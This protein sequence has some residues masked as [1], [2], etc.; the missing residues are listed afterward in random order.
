MTVRVALLSSGLL[1]SSSAGLESASSRLQLGQS[2]RSYPALGD[3]RLR[4]LDLSTIPVTESSEPIALKDVAIGHSGSVGSI[5]FVV[6][7]PGCSLCREHGLQLSELATRH[8]DDKFGLWGIVKETN[9]DDQGLLDFYQQYFTFDIY[10]D[11]LLATYEAMGNRMIRLTTWN[12]I[13][14]YRGFWDLT[15]RLQQKNI[16]GNL[17]G[18]G[19]LQGGILFFDKA[20]VLQ[21]AYEEEIGDEFDVEEILAVLKLMESGTTSKIEQEL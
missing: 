4:S 9:V 16:K 1:L 11:E 21:F 18:E 20:G 6:R 8:F 19:M 3:V 5:A 12:P 15:S 13:R 17:K 7:R 14:W 10:R 2:L